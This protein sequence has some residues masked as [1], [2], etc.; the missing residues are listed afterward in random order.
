MTDIATHKLDVPGVSLTYDVHGDLA[1][2]TDD[3]PVLMIIGSPMDASGF[4]SI[5][6]HFTDR[7]V[8]TYDPRGTGRS[9]RTDAAKQSTPQQHADDIHR[10]IGAVGAGPVDLFAT[11]GG[12]VNAFA[13]VAALPDEVRTLVAHEPPTGAVLPDREQLFAAF[14]DIYDTYLKQGFGPGMAKFI[15]LVSHEG[16]LPTDY[17]ERPAPDPAMFGL[18][19]EDD[20][21]RH[22]PLLAQNM[23]T[24]GFYEPDFDAISDS[25]TRVVVAVGEDSGQQMAA[26]AGRACAERIGA[27]AVVFPGDHGGF[28]G[29]E[30]GQTGKPDQFAAQ[31]R[32]VLDA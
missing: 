3:R 22:D 25:P 31:L 30:Y 17:A 11:S 24:C 13:L 15:A 12:A 5:A 27:A 6:S 10:V 2:A 1:A 4:G 20:G 29:G 8:V 14:R 23:P 18:P 16:Q 9:E 28:L 21:N 26:R 32:D 19:T 7:P